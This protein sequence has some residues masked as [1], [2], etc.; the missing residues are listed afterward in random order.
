[1]A[2]IVAGALLAATPVAGPAPVAQAASG[3]EPGEVTVMTGDESRWSVGY[4]TFVVKAWHCTMY[5]SACDWRSETMLVNNGGR[6]M[7]WI[8]NRSEL[9]AHGPS[10]TI[11]ISKNPEA[12]LTMK[13]RSLGEVRW[14]R[15]VSNNVVTR[16]QMRPS[17]STAWV[18]VRS[19]G[20]GDGPGSYGYVS[21]KCAYA[22]AA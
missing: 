14:K 12:T 5:R 19:C 7:D 8:Q 2:A 17:W 18:S 20:S 13:S 4:G 11:T 16:G 6:I 3:E 21:E 1:M 15:F 9:E 22:G 10:A